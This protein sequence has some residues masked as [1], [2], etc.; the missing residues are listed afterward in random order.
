MKQIRRIILW[1]CFI[2]AVA[3]FYGALFSASEWPQPIQDAVD[4]GWSWVEK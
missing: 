1:L 3:L 2:A 4:A